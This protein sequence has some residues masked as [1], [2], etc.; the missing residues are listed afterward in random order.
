[1]SFL[2]ILLIQLLVILTMFFVYKTTFSPSGTPLSGEWKSGSGVAM[3]PFLKE[4]EGGVRL[5]RKVEGEG[6]LVIPQF[7]GRFLEI[8]VDGKAVLSVGQR[9]VEMLWNEPV[10]VN[11]PE[12]EHE[13]KI[14]LL[15]AYGMVG[16]TT[17]PYI[18]PSVETS[19]KFLLMKFLGSQLFSL[20]FVLPLFLSIFA[21]MVSRSLSNMAMSRSYYLMGIGLLLSGIAI[22]DYTPINLFSVR[23]VRDVVSTAGMVGAFFSP[24]LFIAGLEVR[25]SNGWR[26]TRIA[27]LIG[28]SSLVLTAIKPDI[29]LVYA[30]ES[31]L[32][33]FSTLSVATLNPRYLHPILFYLL[34]IL[35]DELTFLFS[36]GFPQLIPVGSIAFGSGMALAIAR[37]Y[38]EMGK[39][40]EKKNEELSM[41]NKEMMAMN[42]ELE[43]VYKEQE[44]TIMKLGNLINLTSKIVTGMYDFQ[45]E[46]SFLKEILHKAMEMIPEADYGSVAVYE[47]GEW[48]FVDL[49]GHDAE[50]LKNMKFKKEDFIDLRKEKSL[51]RFEGGVALIRDISGKTLNRMGKTRRKEF[52]KATRKISKTL[53]SQLKADDEFLGHLTVDIAKEH[54]AEFSKDSIRIFAA[55]GNIASS[56]LAFKRLSRMRDE[57]QRE[58]ILSIVHVVEIH[59]PYTRGHSESV[60]KI[61]VEIAR[62]MGLKEESIEKAYWAGLVHDIGKI[63]V[64]AEILRKNGRLS[65]EE[66]ELI[67]M[68]PRW[69]YETLVY[70][71]MLK[72]I[73]IYT[74]HHH[75]RWDGKGYP[76]GL[77]RDSIPLISRIISVADTWD[78]MRSD[79]P[80]RKALSLE[81]A[82]R[83]I[84]EAAGSQLDPDIVKVFLERVVDRL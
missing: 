49:I 7:F 31:A 80:Y 62:E 69:S 79:R 54:D 74:R 10:R 15:P 9:E 28:L 11:V 3:V 32:L 72:D 44:S 61:S 23:Y 77:R 24:V 36:K 13:L 41:A 35:H 56:F 33:A 66:Y 25:R 5:E 8:S 65:E 16:L 48:R 14:L 67:K 82:K 1:M 73:A 42:E 39:E 64:P 60:A 2:K 75:E 40:L 29:S 70:S 83:R 81:E 45:D 20:S 38:G 37:E 19:A 4:S 50:K 46:D 6:A 52:E 21:W 43:N 22:V 34:T 59:D 30:Y 58:I 57:F 71:D 84:S 68:H 47:E 18:S 55:L 51:E 26:M 17:T 12:G 27:A 76:D 78:A 63:L 53:V